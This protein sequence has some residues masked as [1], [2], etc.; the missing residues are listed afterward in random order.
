MKRFFLGVGMML[1]A[2]GL[3]QAVSIAELA[4]VCGDDAKAQCAGVGYGDPMQKCLDANYAE[5]S[6]DCQAIMDRLRG[7]EG[8]YLF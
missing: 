4:R 6:K 7:G 1:A 5:L 8:V 3:A 2:T